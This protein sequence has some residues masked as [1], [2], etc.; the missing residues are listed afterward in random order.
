MPSRK[1]NKSRKLSKSYVVQSI[2]IPKSIMTKSEAKKWVAKHYKYIKIDEKVNTYR[3]R[4]IDPSNL[5]KY[6]FR[7]KRLPNGVELVLAYK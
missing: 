2:I 1:S 7:T 5:K 4:Q 3:F 6:K